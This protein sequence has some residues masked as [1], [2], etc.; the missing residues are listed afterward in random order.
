MFRR[1]PVETGRHATYVGPILYRDTCIVGV[2][3]VL[4]ERK[5]NTHSMLLTPLPHYMASQYFTAYHSVVAMLCWE[6]ASSVVANPHD[7]G[8][9]LFITPRGTSAY[10][11]PY[12]DVTDAAADMRLFAVNETV[13][14]NAVQPSSSVSVVVRKGNQRILRRSQRGARTREE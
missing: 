5:C 4:E 13:A 6:G 7:V 12:F 14:R 2:D 3:C 9:H 11:F 8:L 1:V 10:L